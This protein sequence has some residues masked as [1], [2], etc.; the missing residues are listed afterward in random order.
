MRAF[1]LAICLLAAAQGTAAGAG[2]KIEFGVKSKGHGRVWSGGVRETSRVHSIQGWHF[3]AA[4]SVV[5]PAHWNI[6]LEMVGGDVAS[7]AVVVD[8]VGPEAQP[9]TVY[10]RYGDFMFVPAQIRYGHPLDVE[11]FRGDVTVERVPVSQTVTGREFED[12]DPALLRTRGGEYWQA[13]VAY[14]TRKR[15][16]YQ[17]TGADQVT[18]ARSRDGV[19]WYAQT[20]VTAP[21]QLE[22]IL[23]PGCVVD[24]KSCSKSKSL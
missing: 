20:S 6:T 15:D 3:G 23:F 4:D 1:T 17:Y 2:F 7:K 18:I 21:G 8:L 5:R 19:Q 24:R 9:L 13:W 16:G 14:A 22:Q 12:D 10:T 11:M